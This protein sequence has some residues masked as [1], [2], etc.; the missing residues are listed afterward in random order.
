MQDVAR[1]RRRLASAA[2]FL[3]FYI[4]Y[5]TVGSRSADDSAGMAAPGRIIWQ[6]VLDR[7]G[8]RVAQEDKNYLCDYC[9]CAETRFFR[10]GPFSRPT[11]FAVDGGHFRLGLIICADVRY[12]ALC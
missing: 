4:C 2:R 3:G 12:P 10:R 9:A 1:G 11:S 6:V 5:G 7:R 8:E